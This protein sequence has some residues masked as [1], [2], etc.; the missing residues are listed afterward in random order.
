MMTLAWSL[1]ALGFVGLIVYLVLD[2]RKKA[3][4]RAAASKERF[5]RIFNPAGPGPAA[6]GAGSDKAAGEIPSTL[7]TPAALAG[8]SGSY[9]R[10]NSLLDARHARLFELLHAGLPQ[11]AIFAHVSL[12]ALLELTGL[13]EGR[14][15][16]QR[17]RGLAQQ[18][19][20]CVVCSKAFDIVAVVDLE[21]GTTAEARFKAECLKAA[22]V[23]YLRWNP[24]ELPPAG[25]L[26]ALLAGDRNAAAIVH[27]AAREGSRDVASS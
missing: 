14:E 10:R 1:L 6:P 8:T 3:A 7:P 27:P 17:W 26:A 16:E 22:G 21:D 9:A 5:S 11:H 12:A 25:E 2:Y 19:L 20:D 23:P 24:L 18:R 4:A 13:P 15:R